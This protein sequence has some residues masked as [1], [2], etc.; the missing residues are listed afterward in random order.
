MQED[1]SR[2]VCSALQVTLH[3]KHAPNPTTDDPQAYDY[4]LRGL[5][6]FTAKGSADLDYAIEMFTR[7][8]E[9]DPGF[10]KAWTQLTVSLA[11]RQRSR[12]GVPRH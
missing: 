7:A 9:L 4:Y 2:K 1:I 3:A 12:P 8:T 5:G 11:I 10:T 6:F